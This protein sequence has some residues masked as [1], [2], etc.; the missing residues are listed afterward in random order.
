MSGVAKGLRTIHAPVLGLNDHKEE[1]SFVGFHFD[2]KPDNILVTKN[3]IL[4]IT[5]FGQSYI[6]EVRQ[7]YDTYGQFR[8][9][10][11]EYAPPEESPSS[12]DIERIEETS[13]RQSNGK[14]KEAVDPTRLH[15]VYD[16]W[17]LGCIM[18]EVHRYI[19]SRSGSGV[20]AINTFRTLRRNEE[21][22]GFHNGRGLKESVADAID[23]I[24]QSVDKEPLDLTKSALYTYMQGLPS[25]LQKMLCL[26]QA[27]RCTSQYV[28]EELD[29]LRVE[30]NDNNI[31]EDPLAKALR[32]KQYDESLKELV[33]LDKRSCREMYCYSCSKN[34]S[35]SGDIS[36]LLT[37]NIRLNVTFQLNQDEPVPCRLKLLCHKEDGKL[38]TKNIT[39][40]RCFNDSTDEKQ[41][42]ED[43]STK[44]LSRANATNDSLFTVLGEN[45]WPIYLFDK[46]KAMSLRVKALVYSFD[47]LPGKSITTAFPIPNL[48]R[49]N[50]RA[51]LSANNYQPPHFGRARVGLNLHIVP[52][53]CC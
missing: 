44:F 8:G 15:N 34:L 31:P 2:L 12:K 16:V 13:K 48:T 21:G 17:S 53:R 32:T 36:S 23:Q 20:P 40:S 47:S 9:G 18:I 25:L 49:W 28:V 14:D 29:R 30:F 35:I 27:D 3:G 41:I 5:D 39:I 42:I 43:S 51:E 45:F 19:F 22:V 46:T 24:D 52:S 7:G 11:F 26:K 1:T 50:R 4:K 38:I 6:K 10:A 37:T 33:T